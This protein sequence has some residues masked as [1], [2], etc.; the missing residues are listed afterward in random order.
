MHGLKSWLVSLPGLGK[1]FKR[2]APG[3]AGADGAPEK[4]F[5]PLGPSD[6]LA[7]K[8]PRPAD[9]FPAT[10]PLPVDPFPPTRP[11]GSDPYLGSDPQAPA[12]P[13]PEAKPP[14]EPRN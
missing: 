7:A 10:R 13:A 9:P 2:E 4:I 3:P 8:E 11:L 6:M 1:L 12:A 14:G 5:T